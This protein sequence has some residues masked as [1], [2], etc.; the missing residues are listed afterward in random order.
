MNPPPA[1]APMRLLPLALGL[2][3]A[4]GLASL[5]LAGCGGRAEGP[6]VVRLWHQKDAGER[7]FL[8]EWVDRFNAGQDSVRLEVL[9]KET[10]E[11]RNHYV[12]AA[13][14]GKG[15]EL[16]YGP[17]D[18]VGTF[19]VTETVAPLDGRLDAAFLAGFT[20]DGLLR[21]DGRIVGVADQ[22]GNHLT[23]VYN[24]ALIPEPPATF[25]ELI[26][27]GQRLTRDTN[28][29]GRPDRYAL[30]WNYTEPFFFIPFLTAFGGWVM[31][32]E[33]RPTL[34][35]EAT[36]RAIRFVLDLR[37]RY[38]VI[39]READYETVKMLF[40][41]GDA[42]AVIDGSWAWASYGDSG[43]DYML[44]PLPLNTATG[45][46]AQPMFAAKAYSVNPAV[47]DEAWPAVRAVLEYLT[48]P[49]I[50]RAMAERLSTIPVQ[51]AVL[52]SDV[53]TRNPYLRASLAQI[54]HARPMP[55][56][57]QM[58]QIW[59]AMRGPYQLV[60]NGAVSPEQGARMMQEAAE[61]RIADTFLN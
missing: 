21:W 51:R 2:G 61:K 18:N 54:E 4:A 22:V 28:G 26:A 53:M 34:D 3:L 5:G 13:I 49:E 23:Y 47:T 16:V 58:R 19:G 8:Q 11:L 9:Y 38:Q 60:M 27:M 31:D 6:R 15:P 52:E 57:P 40:R 36:V 17:A 48:G 12:F 24:R 25:D 35:T 29:D 45:E 30:A 50:Q 42:A 41:E 55:T 46:W 56:A 43:V 14:G 37:D 39:P 20:D 7:A 44:A 1:P 59:D 33:G 10:E 32:D